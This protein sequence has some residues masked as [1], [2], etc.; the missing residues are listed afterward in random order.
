[1]GDRRASEQ[2]E[3]NNRSD[4]P[5]PKTSEPSKPALPA[6]TVLNASDKAG[7]GAAAGDDGGVT[8]RRLPGAL[9]GPARVVAETGADQQHAIAAAPPRETI[10]FQP[11]MEMP[12]SDHCTWSQRT[13]GTFMISCR[14]VAP[15]ATAARVATSGSSECR[16]RW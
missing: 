10:A 16:S 6:V 2:D 1:M 12:N 13:S 7:A 15:V 8:R 5:A 3:S 4:E 11:A 9:V 14:L